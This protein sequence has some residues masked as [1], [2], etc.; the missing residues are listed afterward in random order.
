MPAAAAPTTTAGRGPFN[1]TT[2]PFSSTADAARRLLDINSPPPKLPRR[3]ADLARRASLGNAP[4]APGTLAAAQQGASSAQSQQEQQA[5]L[6]RRSLETLAA[7][8]VGGSAPSYSPDLSLDPQQ[9]LQALGAGGA[10]GFSS[11]LL[12]NAELLQQLQ[13]LQALRELQAA[14]AGMG[15]QLQGNEPSTSGPLGAGPSSNMQEDVGVWPGFLL[16]ASQAPMEMGGMSTGSQNMR[17][18]SGMDVS[19]VG[20]GVLPQMGSGGPSQASAAAQGSSA[21]DAVVSWLMGG[22]RGSDAGR[23]LQLPRTSAPQM[24]AVPGRMSLDSA[25][26]AYENMQ[27]S[28][29]M[30]QMMSGINW[31]AL[32]VPSPEQQQQQQEL[33]PSQLLLQ[34]QQQLR[35]QQQHE[36]D[37]TQSHQT[38]PPYPH[39]AMSRGSL[40]T[41]AAQRASYDGGLTNR[42]AYDTLGTVRMSFDGHALARAASQQ[43]QAASQP[44]QLLLAQQQQAQQQLQPSQQAQQQQQPRMQQLQQ[45]GRG[46]MDSSQARASFESARSTWENFA[47][48]AAGE[49]P[50]AGVGRGAGGLSLDALKRLRESF[51]GLGANA[52]G[53]AGTGLPSVASDAGR[54]G[55][56]SGMYSQQGDAAAGGRPRSSTPTTGSMGTGSGARLGA[57]AEMGRDTSSEY[58]SGNGSG[59]LWQQ[60]QQSS[61]M[62][63]A[64]GGGSG[65]GRTGSMPGAPGTSSAGGPGAGMAG[66]SQQFAF[67]GFGNVMTQQQGQQQEQ[68]DAG[69]AALL[70]ALSSSRS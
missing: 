38:V 29:G 12:S 22:Q 6:L 34:A 31:Q 32:R 47:G 59:G 2:G 23:S 13:N 65:V 68:Q 51:W 20:S 24:T 21:D 49:G 67:P 7:G 41:Q 60:L 55:G 46:S 5:E 53:S 17:G 14:A 54:V 15:M 42:A 8:G 69:L 64:G 37:R 4:S 11:G 27:I 19:G 63:Q 18:G 33:T 50:G 39:Y 36:R 40:D 56:S 58:Q 25:R 16:N 43:H 10:S 44:L 52:P 1:S 61:G 66:A 48:G 35:Q 26:S 70:A 57:G 45:A 28:A 30:Q 3:L 9:Q 62:G